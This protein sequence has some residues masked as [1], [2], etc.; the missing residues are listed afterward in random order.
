MVLLIQLAPLEAYVCLGGG[1]CIQSSHDAWG[2][3]GH[4]ARVITPAGAI[5]D[6]CHVPARVGFSLA[7]GQADR[8]HVPFSREAHRQCLGHETPQSAIGVRSEFA[9]CAPRFSSLLRGSHLLRIGQ[10]EHSSHIPHGNPQVFNGDIGDELYLVSQIN[11]E[12]RKPPLGERLTR[13][14]VGAVGV[15]LQAPAKPVDFPVVC[16]ARPRHCKP[17]LHWDLVVFYTTLGFNSFGGL[18]SR[19]LGGAPRWI[20]FLASATGGSH[21]VLSTC[22]S[23][24]TTHRSKLPFADRCTPST[25][26][27]TAGILILL[28]RWAFA[29][30]PKGGCSKAEEASLRD[31]VP[32]FLAVHVGARRRLRR[33]D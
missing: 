22:Y 30:R 11:G 12:T 21:I 16:F 14:R 10:G 20:D 8:S 23:E 15:G 13:Q 17:Y 26:A 29:P 4:E 27:S 24:Q 7:E 19:W 33:H 25:S 9:A 32:V 28:A 3:S 31:L 6:F 2:L 18:P 1:R 5:L